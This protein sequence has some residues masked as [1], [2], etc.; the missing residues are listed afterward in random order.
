MLPSARNDNLA[1]ALRRDPKHLGDRGE[2]HARIND[3]KNA[4]LSFVESSKAPE[5]LSAR[6]HPGRL[7]LLRICLQSLH[8]WTLARSHGENRT[9]PRT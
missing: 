1:Y 7:P 3:V 8:R 5:S 9:G 2:R 4:G 6:L